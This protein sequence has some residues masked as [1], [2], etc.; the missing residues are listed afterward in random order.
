MSEKKYEDVDLCDPK[1]FVDPWEMYA[2]FQHHDPI[3]WDPNNEIWYAFRYDDIV[4]IARDPETFCSTNGNRPNL[5][6]DPSMIHK[7][8]DAH[9]WQRGLVSQGFTPRRMRKMEDQVHGMVEEMIA[10]MMSKD[11]C[12]VVLDLAAKLPMRLIGDMLGVPREKHETVRQW[13]AGMVA[14]GN[15]PQYVDDVVN[16]SFEA[17]TE[18]HMEMVAERES[19]DEQGDDLLTVWMNAELD[20]E[21]LDESQLL[22]EHVLLNVGGAETTR[23]A[24][25]GGLEQL[26]YH[27]EQ[28]DYLVANRDAIPNA[29]E[30]IIR[31]V[32]PFHNM[33]RTATRD[34]EM[35]GKT[36]QEGQMIGMQFSAANRDPQHFK[37]PHQFDIK[38]NFNK[39]NSKHIAFGYG[40]HFCLGSSLAR[41]ELR[42]VLEQMTEKVK[43]IRI[44]EGKKVEW[45]ESSFTRGPE[46][47]PAILDVR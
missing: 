12:D 13:I 5:P 15:G 6:P 27:P 19:Q 34:V 25:A 16:D 23:N 31:F 38:R 20:G 46:T 22:F 4:N 26:V 9:T 35:H 40:T 45:F 32:S 30:E 21:K 37:N 43:R 14:G 39:P 29:C 8:G 28:W 44:P 41:L 33:F 36:I 24:I 42:T 17:F 1:T 7:D 3:H 47:F 10:D 18:H 11:E 2:Y